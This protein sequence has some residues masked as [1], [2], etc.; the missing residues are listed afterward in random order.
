MTVNTLPNAE[1]ATLAPS[2]LDQ[3]ISQLN[4]ISWQ[5]RVSAAKSLAMAGQIAIPHLITATHSEHFSVRYAATWALGRIGGDGVIAA[6]CDAL[7]D[8]HWAVRETAAHSLGKLKSK[9][10]VPALMEA[11]GD[12]A[13]QVRYAAIDALASISNNDS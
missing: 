6:L 10:A 5:E 4:S 3:W 11:T 13:K 2:K 12:D 1:Q 9:H 8:S 7:S